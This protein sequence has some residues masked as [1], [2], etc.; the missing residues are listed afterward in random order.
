MVIVV[1]IV[2]STCLYV[3]VNYWNKE[4]PRMSWLDARGNREQKSRYSYVPFYGV[5]GRDPWP[6][7][8]E[9]MNWAIDRA[10]R[11]IGIQN[12]GDAIPSE[13]I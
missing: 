2:A 13:R 5:A 11:R 3:N 1:G 10:H 6:G 4:Q 7:Y 9:G 12:G 8:R